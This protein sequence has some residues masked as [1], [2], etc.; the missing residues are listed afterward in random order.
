MTQPVLSQWIGIKFLTPAQTM[1]M[2]INQIDNLALI[3]SLSYSPFGMPLVCLL[4]IVFHV[5]QMSLY[6]LFI[7]W[8]TFA[9]PI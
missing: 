8:Y 7:D 3:Y 2:V 6:A 4:Q 5:I 1:V 9:M